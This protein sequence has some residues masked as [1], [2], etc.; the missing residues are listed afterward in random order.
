MKKSDVLVDFL[1]PRHTGLSIRF[2]EGLYYKKK[3]ITDNAAV[4]NYDFYH[5]DNIFVIENNNYDEIKNFLKTPYD[6][7]PTEIVEK[8]GFRNWIQEIIKD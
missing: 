3:V 7:L 6:D 8:Y 4:K 1:D 2:F 5:K